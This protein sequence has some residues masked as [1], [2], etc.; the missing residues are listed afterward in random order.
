SCTSPPP[1]CSRS[2]RRP[3]FGRR[4]PRRS[5]GLEPGLLVH[6]E[7][8]VPDDRLVKL[9]ARAGD[10]L[11]REKPYRRRLHRHLLL[12]RLQERVALLRIELHALLL[13]EAVDIREARASGVR[14]D[15]AEVLTPEALE[16]VVRA[17]GAGTAER[18]PPHL[19]RARLR[20]GAQQL[21]VLRVLDDTQLD[22][23]A[24]GLP[25]LEHRL[26]DLE[27]LQV[28]PLRSDE[29]RAEAVRVACLGE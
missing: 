14:A 19:E 16:H 8:L 25:H 1:W 20:V 7:R 3:R 12:R 4:A 15:R 28:D 22:P 29:V 2:A 10:L 23:H 17:P 24:D 11:D 26:L 5:S 18:V 9:R 21:E 13:R 27:I 6:P